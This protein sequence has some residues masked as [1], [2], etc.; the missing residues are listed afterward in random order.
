M[1]PQ[2]II[3]TARTW[4]GVP[5]LHQGRTRQ[6]VDC[7]GLLV[8]IGEE[9]GA[10]IIHPGTYSMSP[11]PDLVLGALVA[12]C[13]QVPVAQARP[14]DVLLMSFAGEPRHVGLLTD[15]GLLHAWAKPGKVVEHRMDGAWRR[16][17]RSAWRPC[18]Y[19]GGL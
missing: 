16:R 17:I 10:A 6:G 11:D 19:G 4:L 15:A 8:A 3:A 14:G 18:F 5:F 12:N 7:G 13:S 9:A 1:T 2:E